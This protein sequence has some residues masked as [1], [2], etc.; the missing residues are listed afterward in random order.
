M[1]WCA[2]HHLDPLTDIRRPRVE[3]SVPR[4]R[5]PSRPFMSV[6][7]GYRHHPLEPI[8]PQRT[9][10]SLPRGGLHQQCEVMAS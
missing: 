5:L 4:L 9:A 8:S 6:V 1:A 2:D 7:A 10:E 3:L